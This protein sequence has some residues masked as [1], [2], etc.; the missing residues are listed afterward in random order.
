MQLSFKKIKETSNRKKSLSNAIK[1][2]QNVTQATT[3]HFCKLF[4]HEVLRVYYQPFLAS[5][6][7]SDKQ[8]SIAPTMPSTHVTTIFSYCI[9]GM[10]END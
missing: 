2:Q 7:F 4:V 10:F 8:I 6:P 3:N 5:A 1:Q 9:F